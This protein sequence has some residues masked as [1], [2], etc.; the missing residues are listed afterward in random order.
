M[1]V[2]PIKSPLN[3][4]QVVGVS[5]E[6]D[7]HN[8]QDWRRRVNNFTGRSLTHT[9][10]RTEQSGRSGRIVSLGQLLSPGVVDGLVADKS[11]SQITETEQKE[12]LDITNGYG[13][14]ASGETR[15]IE[16]STA[17]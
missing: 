2:F 6:L 17:C 13:L 10:L 12:F 3:G 7:M 1:K 16:Y 15:N 8:D 14:A 9:A 11:A 4:E 5:P